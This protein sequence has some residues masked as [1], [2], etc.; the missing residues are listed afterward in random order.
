MNVNLTI[1]NILDEREIA[2]SNAEIA[3]MSGVCKSQVSRF[4]KHSNELSF[5]DTLKLIR[6]ICPTKENDL[7]DDIIQGYIEEAKPLNLKCAS[8]YY[9]M[10]EQEAK[11]EAIFDVDIFNNAHKDWKTLVRIF[12]KYK[13]RDYNVSETQVALMNTKT[14][15][16]ESDSL[17]LLLQSYL[18]YQRKN[19][20]N[21]FDLV[22]LT[23]EKIAKIKNDFIRDYF[24]NLTDEMY[25]ASHLFQRND[26]AMSR[27]YLERIRKNP[28]SC[29]KMMA[30]VEYTTALS[31]LFEDFNY[32][33]A[34]FEYCAKEWRELGQLDRV[35]LVEN[36]DIPFLYNYWK[37]EWDF[38]SSEA[39][40]NHVLM[41]EAI[42]GSDLTNDERL[43]K[44]T[45]DPFDIFIKGVVKRDDSLLMLSAMAYVN[46]HNKFFAKLPLQYVAGSELNELI[47]ITL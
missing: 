10:M 29:R 42:A 45:N 20:S 27:F 34:S 32:S 13:K 43:D 16:V 7:T 1:A 6:F 37:K 15:S 2:L 33:L 44:L 9:V 8:L 28:L 24:R 11:L 3:A 4:L 41:K 25:A 38:D 40:E 39:F 22:A 47:K 21:M 19:Y 12:Y 5:Y 31:Y 30:N 46:S 36:D 26:T 14:K 35:H 17:K 18:Y 23:E